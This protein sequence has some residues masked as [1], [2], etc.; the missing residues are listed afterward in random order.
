MYITFS[1]SCLFGNVLTCRLMSAE[2]NISV[3]EF[4]RVDI[5]VG[6]ILRAEPFPEARAPGIK[7]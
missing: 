4:L 1:F 7:L 2:M 6:T 5:R 3:N